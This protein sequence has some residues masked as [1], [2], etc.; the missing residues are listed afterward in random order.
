MAI[1]FRLI[2]DN[3]EPSTLYQKFIHTGLA[4]GQLPL[5][6]EGD[7]T[8]NQSLTIAKYVARGTSLIPDDPWQ[9]AVAENLAFTV[10]D[11]W[12]SKYKVLL[13][14]NLKN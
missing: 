9:Q 2:V 7:H 13:L 14:Y 11:Y 12:S 8:L 6:K 4:F 1:Y 3:L 10:Y 5:Y